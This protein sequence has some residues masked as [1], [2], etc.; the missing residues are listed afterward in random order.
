MLLHIS[1]EFRREFA[2]QG[3]FDTL[4]DIITQRCH[5]KQNGQKSM[6]QLSELESIEAAV[7]QKIPQLSKLRTQHNFSA[8]KSNFNL[9]MIVLDAATGRFDNVYVMFSEK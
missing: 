5:N 8:S 2:S 9:N 6:I 3:G 1:E 7:V 4:S